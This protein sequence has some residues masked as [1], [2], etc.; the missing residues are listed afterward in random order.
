[1]EN[2]PIC[3]VDDSGTKRWF[4][5]GKFHRLDG[6]AVE[7]TNGTFAWFKCGKIH[8]LDGPAVL[9]DNGDT[10]WFI[11]NYDVTKEITKW[12][13]ENDID[14]ENLTEV[15]KTLIK[16]TWIDYGS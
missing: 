2:K 8:R 10:N 15:D 5:N 11:N 14:L 9:W 1:M 16:L 7:Y 13:K 12:A 6:P 3:N 4:Q